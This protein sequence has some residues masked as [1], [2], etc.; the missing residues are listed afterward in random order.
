MILALLALVFVFV[1]WRMR[2][3]G[4]RREL[5]GRNATKPTYM[6]EVPSR[7]VDRKQRGTL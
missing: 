2:R 3:R 5:A 4:F 6:V 1:L 7:R